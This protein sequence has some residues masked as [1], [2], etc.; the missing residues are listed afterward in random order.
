MTDAALL[1]AGAAT[2]LWGRVQELAAASGGRVALAAARDQLR[3]ALPWLDLEGSDAA[4]LRR[5]IVR[6][7]TPWLYRGEAALGPWG[8][9]VVRPLLFDR[10][11]DFGSWALEKLAM[12]GRE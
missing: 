1:C 12:W 9:R 2:P 8:S 7:M 4:P 11:R 10:A 6:G 3:L 5:A